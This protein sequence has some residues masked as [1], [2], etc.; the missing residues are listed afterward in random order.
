MNF[1]MIGQEQCDL[2]IQVTSWA[3]L[4]VYISTNSENSDRNDNSK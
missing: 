1:V 2:L 3:C 4:T